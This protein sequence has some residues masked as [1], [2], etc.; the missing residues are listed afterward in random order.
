[1]TEL[2]T[3]TPFVG[4]FSRAGKLVDVAFHVKVRKDC[5]L[6]P[7]FDPTLSSKA[8]VS[9][10]GDRWAKLPFKGIFTHG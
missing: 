1:M 9:D 8:L 7:E 10:T 4:S 2:M 6:N 5:R 3:K